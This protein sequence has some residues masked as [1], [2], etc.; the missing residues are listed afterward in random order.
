MD[1]RTNDAGAHN[2]VVP[3]YFSKQQAASAGLD[4]NKAYNRTGFNSAILVVNVGEITGT[5]DSFSVAVKLQHR[6]VGGVFADL[7]DAAITSITAANSIAIKNVDLSGAKAEIQARIVVTMTGGSTPKATMSV[8]LVLGGA[9]I[10]P[11]TAP[12]ALA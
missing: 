12:T 6:D 11:A 5:P 2:V 4:S 9:V 8:D 7:T 3:L 10:V 1:P